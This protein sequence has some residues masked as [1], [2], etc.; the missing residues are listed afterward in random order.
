MAV[1][2]HYGEFPPEEL[3]W[4][5]LI[6]V[7][8]PASMAV[9]RYDGTL[10]AVPNAS[11]LL[12]PLITQEAVL[13]SRIEGTQTTMGEVLEYEAEGE[14][15]AIEPGKKADIQEVLNYRRALNRSVEM[16]RDLPLCQRIIRE[17]HRVLLDGVRG[18]GKDP[19]EYRK[20]QNWIGP[21]GCTLEEARFV[22]ISPDRLPDGMSAWERHIH[23]G[24]QDH[25]VRLAVLHAEFEALHPFHDGNGRLGRMM[26]PLYMYEKGLISGPM[27][28]IS[29]YFEAHRD[30][31]YER[32]LAVSREGAWT[33][34]CLFFLEAVRQQAE[35]NRSKAQAILDLYEGMKPRFTE[36][37]RSQHAISA[38]DRIFSHPIFNSGNF[39]E[40]SGI[41]VA[42]ARRILRELREHDV[43]E[44]LLESSG[45][46][47]A[48]YVF[49]ELLRIT[50]G[51]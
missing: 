47:S 19:G 8:G 1:Q 5:R 31:Y 51:R 39:I 11:L 34:W 13:S 48:V 26:V 37:T 46:R 24:A 17:A 3:D 18:Q 10:S 41:P 23:A 25:L 32:L 30:E 50:E 27:F 43:L 4:K 35:E 15:K 38:L 14:S 33:E 9:A 40:A 44:V 7:I 28:Y 29:A 49:P 16:M 20:N 21:H 6:P 45:R 22:P 36:I 12:S 2:Y 42:T